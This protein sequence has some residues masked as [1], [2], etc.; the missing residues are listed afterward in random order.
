MGNTAGWYPDPTGRGEQRYWDGNAWTDHATRAGVQ[1]TDPASAVT[2]Q[3][4]ARQQSSNASRGGPG[5]SA[6][7]LARSSSAS[8]AA[9]KRGLTDECTTA[10]GANLP[11]M[12]R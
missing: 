2:A 10:T 3:P 6:G 9:P 11:G 1:G 7:Y 4:M 12:M 8:V 5:C